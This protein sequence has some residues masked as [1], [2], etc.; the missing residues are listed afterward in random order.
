MTHVFM[1]VV[2]IGGQ[3]VSRDMHFINVERCNYFASQLSK[4]YGKGSF[5][6]EQNVLAYCLPKLVDTST[7][8]LYN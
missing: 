3:T 7:I 6:P 8:Q 5:P 2:M 1:L 4:R